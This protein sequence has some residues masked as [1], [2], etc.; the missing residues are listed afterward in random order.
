MF[1]HHRLDRH[2][3]ADSP[4]DH[5][6]SRIL[7]RANNPSMHIAQYY[8]ILLSRLWWNPRRAL[9][10]A[11]ACAK[12]PLLPS[13]RCIYGHFW[14]LV[15]D[16]PDDTE[17]VQRKNRNRYALSGYLSVDRTWAC[18]CKLPH[19]KSGACNDRICHDVTCR[20]LL[21]QQL[22][23]I[24]TGHV[25]VGF[26]NTFETSVLVQCKCKR[27]NI[28]DSRKHNSENSENE[29]DLRFGRRMEETL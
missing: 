12:I 28:N 25:G 13:N 22:V 16:F 17:V 18:T 4:L 15:Y 24:D 3:C 8:G 1:L 11:G 20:L 29:T 10:A 14:Q 26:E 27:R 7:Q 21:L 19:Q 2:W 9:F 6:E 23:V 5:L